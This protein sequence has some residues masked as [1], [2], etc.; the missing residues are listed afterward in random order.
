MRTVAVVATAV[1]S[2]AIGARPTDA[3]SADVQWVLLPVRGN[4]PPPRD[5]TLLRLT[6]SIGRAVHRLGLGGVRV[7]SRTIRDENCP[8]MDGV[9]PKEVARRVGGK[10]VLSMTLA[11]DYRSLTVRVYGNRGLLR[12]GQLPCEWSDGSAEC[13]TG[14]L[15]ALLEPPNR[16]GDVKLVYH[17]FRRLR[18]QLR[19]CRTL[20]WGGL[21][22]EDPP[23]SMSIRFRVSRSGLIEGVRLDPP[24]YTDVP[25][26]ACMA[27]VV[28]TLQLPK[29]AGPLKDLVTFRLPTL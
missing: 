14:A 5:P 15:T 4:R 28:E 27:R 20:G 22:E 18:R 11:P 13:R 19:K 16:K 29:R 9:C 10:E 2:L 17:R 26:Y 8:S 6:K 21:E 1:T 25:G 23:S 12:V 24:G 7:V 3:G